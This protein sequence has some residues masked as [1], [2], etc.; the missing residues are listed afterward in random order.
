MTDQGTAPTPSGTLRKCPTGISGLDEIT[1]GGLPWGRPTLLC[2][3]PGC[4]K[5]VLAMEFI[6][7]GV[8]EYGEPG[9][10]VSFEESASSLVDNFR[11]MG[12]DLEGLVR[13]ERL[14]LA[15]IS[16]PQGE[17]VE[18]GDY[19]LDGFLIQL[20][21]GIKQVGAKRVALDS[22]DSLFTH[23]S[24]T[25]LMRSEIARLFDWLREKGVTTVVTGERG[26][27]D[28][29]RYGFE[30]YLS[31]CVLLLDH[32]ISEQIS[33]R[34]LRVVKYRG[35]AHSADEFPF[36]VGSRGISVFPIT[37]VQM[38]D[39]IGSERVGT[40]VS[41]IDDMFGGEG[42]Y[43]GS[44]ILVSGKAGTGKSS[45]SAAFV[46]AACRRGESALYLALEESSGQVL[47]NMRS[48][49]IDLQHWV[50]EGLL[51]VRA[52]RPTLRGLEE[53]LVS[54]IQAIDERRPSCIAIDPITN[55][56]TVGNSDEVGGMLT[57]LL[58]HVKG[59]GITLFLTA[60]TPVSGSVEETDTSV[61]STVDSWIALEQ[62]LDG[63]QRRRR[64]YIV[65][66]R[67]MRHAHDIRE[68]IMS[69]QGLSVRPLPVSAP[70]I[71]EAEDS[72][73]S[74]AA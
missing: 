39:E 65:K 63:T 70:V 56:V 37:S 60:L 9:I 12:F 48:V 16:V 72:R 43:R 59:L 55:F 40:G 36:L 10:F 27:E 6:V 33:K 74:P 61:S 21:Q 29:T 45:L 32:R 47:R 44:T 8:E 23:L 66:S 30:E 15:Y 54:I 4:G 52:F 64:I 49:G 18:A 13:Q 69:S 20:E 46:D 22:L 24:D 50:D 19:S 11:P 62:I 26:K 34:R 5:T 73:G 53:H 51:G 31:D 17:I 67:G 25:R 2:G 28:L 14:K 41:D 58:G 1:Y 42:F 71:R 7:R 57:R 68:F 3:T 35:S 38:E